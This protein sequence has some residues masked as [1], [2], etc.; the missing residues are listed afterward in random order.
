MD[1]N[2]L[3]WVWDSQ[4]TEQTDDEDLGWKKSNGDHRRENPP[5]ERHQ[6]AQRPPRLAL[7]SLMRS[8]GEGGVTEGRKRLLYLV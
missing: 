1:I 7:P 3:G 2:T 5:Y 6:V 8:A 4:E